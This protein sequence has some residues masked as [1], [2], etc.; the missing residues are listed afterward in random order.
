MKVKLV[1][2]NYKPLHKIYESLVHN[3]PKGVEYIVPPTKNKFKMLYKYYKKFRYFEMVKPMIYAFER[4]FFVSRHNNHDVD[5]YQYINMIDDRPPKKPYV[6]DI[7]YAASLVSFIPNK[8]RLKKVIAFLKNNNCKS[9]NCLSKAANDSLKMLLG[10]E[11][12]NIASKVRVTYPALEE[13]SS[14]KYKPDYSYIPKSNKQINVLFVGNQAYLKGLEE[15][16]IATKKF[17]QNYSPEKLHLHIISDDAGKL[18]EKYGA[19]NISLYAPKFSKKDIIT[20]FFLPAD[21]FVM[22]TKED[23]FGMA[24]LDSLASGTAVVATDQFAIPEL[25]TNNVDGILLRL[26]EPILNKVAVPLKEDMRA[27]T[28]SNIDKK[29]ADQ[30]YEVLGSLVKGDVDIRKLGHNGRMKFVKGG[31]F[32]IE[33]RNKD[34]LHIYSNSIR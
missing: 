7:E 31:R 33:S 16:L 5:I 26:K 30:L 23:T 20:M 19:E 2:R 1:Y 21:V 4:F 25:V 8:K 14:K 27:V 18:L 11:Y 10:N 22:P 15:L 29:L 3:P 24:I 34:L 28:E 13:I 12:K 9:V 32:S 17:N 6:V